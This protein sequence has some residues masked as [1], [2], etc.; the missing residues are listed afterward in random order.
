MSSD[1]LWSV[2]L[3]IAFE[4]P[5]IALLLRRRR[6]PEKPMLQDVYRLAQRARH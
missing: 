1:N 3:L 5:F 2:A 4:L 6:P